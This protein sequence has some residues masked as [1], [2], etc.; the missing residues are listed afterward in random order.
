MFFHSQNTRAAF[1]WNSHEYYIFWEMFCEFNNLSISYKP[2]LIHLQSDDAE[3][4]R[5]Q[6]LP[7]FLSRLENINSFRCIFG[8]NSLWSRQ[9]QF[10]SFECSR[11][12]SN[13]IKSVQFEIF[14]TLSIDWPTLSRLHLIKYR[15]IWHSYGNL[16]AVWIASIYPSCV[17]VRT[18]ESYLASN[19]LKR[20]LSQTQTQLPDYLAFLWWKVAS[21]F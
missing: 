12:E 20:D 11:I 8:I 5:A 9:A 17:H 15:W 21:M 6:N 18:T 14:D 1:I 2:I 13:R 19:C 16:N 7:F 4:M 10:I 3:V